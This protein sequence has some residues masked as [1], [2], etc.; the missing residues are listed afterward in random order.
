[1]KKAILI[2]SASVALYA[3]CKKDDNPT[4]PSQSGITGK[5]TIESTH[6]KGISGGELFDTT[7]LGTPGEYVDVRSDG[8]AYSYQKGLYDTTSYKLLD[9][10]RIVFLD[11]EDPSASD[12]AQ[13]KTLT[14]N[15]LVIYQKWVQGEDFTEVTQNLKK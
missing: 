1:M 10:S 11:E 3:S 5:W 9:N 14:K 4:T 13:I 15:S 6:S 7:I 2:L 12:T 8:K